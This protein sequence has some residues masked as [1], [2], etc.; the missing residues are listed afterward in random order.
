LV[1][2]LVGWVTVSA[3]WVTVSVVVVVVAATSCSFAAPVAV[4]TAFSAS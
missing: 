2:V 4:D 3:G 1:T